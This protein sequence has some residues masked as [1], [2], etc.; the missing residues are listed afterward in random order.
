MCKAPRLPTPKD[1]EK[2]EFL[3]NPYLDAAIGQA[4]VVDQLRTG[5][6]KLRIDIGSGLGLRKPGE[7]LTQPNPNIR[8]PGK[9][10]RLQPGGLPPADFRRI[11]PPLASAP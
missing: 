1:P 4:G 3:R 2:P 7:A 8:P 10:P 5:R 11:L 6:S 9:R